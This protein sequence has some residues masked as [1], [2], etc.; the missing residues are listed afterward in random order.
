MY[1]WIFIC[2][3][4]WHIFAYKGKA[5]FI[6]ECKVFFHHFLTCEFL[7]YLVQFHFWGQE[8][9]P[10]NRA[11]KEGMKKGFAFEYE[12]CPELSNSVSLWTVCG[13]KTE[14]KVSVKFLFKFFL[15]FSFIMILSIICLFYQVAKPNIGE[16]HPASVRAD[17]TLTLNLRPQVK[18]EWECK[19]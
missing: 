16:N 2:V 19:I 17:V 7:F 15:L 6:L 10:R 8:T 11:Y 18:A 3:C 12:F 14:K 5:K 4:R 13:W 1:V 9:K